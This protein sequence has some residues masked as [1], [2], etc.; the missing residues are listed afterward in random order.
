MENGR[1]GF[2]TYHFPAVSPGLPHVSGPTTMATWCIDILC[3]DLLDV[4][5]CVLCCG[6]WWS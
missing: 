2:R 1:R 6:R 4:V 3:V 5:A